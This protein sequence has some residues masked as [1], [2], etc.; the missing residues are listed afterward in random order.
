MGGVVDRLKA[1]L[2]H[3]I[4]QPGYLRPSLSK[5]PLN[6]R[7]YGDK[8]EEAEWHVMARDL[9]DPTEIW[10]YS[11]GSMDDKKVAGAGWAVYRSDELLAEGSANT[12]SWMEV[13][14]AGA[15]GARE[16][17][18]TAT[19]CAAG[20]TE[21]I[22][23]FLNNRSMV[24]RIS[25]PSG[26]IGTSQCIIDE[27]RDAL[28][29]LSSKGEH[30]R[31]E[32]AWV[33][34]YTEVPGNERADRLAKGGIKLPT[35]AHDD[36][37]RASKAL[38]ARVWKHP[39]EGVGR[40]TVG[41]IL[42]LLPAHGDYASYHRWLKHESAVLTCAKCEAEKT[43]EHPWGCPSRDKRLWPRF[44]NKLALTDQGFKYLAKNLHHQDLPGPLVR[45]AATFASGRLARSRLDNHIGEFRA[46]PHGLP[47]GSPASPVLFLLYLE[48]LLNVMPSSFGYA[49]DVAFLCTA[50]TLEESSRL[51]DTRGSQA[52]K[53]C[54]DNGL[55]VADNKTEF[56]YLHRTQ[57]R[58]PQIKVNGANHAAN[59][60]TR[61]LGMFLNTKLS[62]KTHMQH[63]SAKAMKTLAEVSEPLGKF[64]EVYDAEVT[65]ALVGLKAALASPCIRFA[66]DVHVILD[67]QQASES[68]LDSTP[69]L[70]S[71]R[72]IIEFRELAA[73][74]PAQTISAI[75]R[76]R[77][78]RVVWCPGH[79]GIEGNER[80]DALAKAACQSTSARPTATVA[81]ARATTRRHFLQKTTKW[82][83]RMAPSTYR[84]LEI[85][86]PGGPPKELRLPRRHLGFLIQCRTDHG[87][88]MPYHERFEHTEAALYCAYGR[89]KASTHLAACPTVRERLATLGRPRGFGTLA[90]VF[91][92]PTGAA[93][94]STLLHKTQFLQDLCPLHHTTGG[95]AAVQRPPTP[96]QASPA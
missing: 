92:T 75:A 61:W 1:L 50:K 36:V 47:Q 84:E 28:T 59:D 89:P 4:T 53:W 71:Q 65:G 72:E 63:W 48:P 30:H 60:S 69:T 95:T 8:E 74:W 13:A 51:A 73:S 24:D 90:F 57:Q 82:W 29:Q 11:D 23:V 18:K 66:T 20:D 35:A 22:R 9:A 40:K 76:P 2:P 62:S 25:Y 86:W 46:I 37:S 79:V 16:A 31:A 81:G 88:C 41:T 5:L 12:G 85:S 34:G 44:V 33:P 52:R 19:H 10:A 91:G 38:E 26:H 27:I 68:L 7:A 56:Q 54:Y 83:Q 93:R 94:L 43:L 55:T 64:H 58:A 49:D 6:R 39:Y 14:D 42:G 87:D 21:T 45:C 3:P 96:T 32:V 80:A 67:N 77:R 78:V 70:T 17:L 15:I